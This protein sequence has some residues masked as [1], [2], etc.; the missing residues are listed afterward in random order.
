[1]AV[2]IGPRGGNP[3]KGQCVSRVPKMSNSVEKMSKIEEKCVNLI[4][5]VKMILKEM[6]K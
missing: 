4:L 6:E 3:S 2:V 5:L 1:M